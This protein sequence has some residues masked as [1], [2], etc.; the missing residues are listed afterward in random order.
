MPPYPR[1]YDT[2]A[3]CDYHYGAKGHS[4]ENC[5]ALMCKVQDLMKAGYVS[6]NYNASGVS[7]ITNNPL[8]NHP[9]PKINALTEDSTG[10]LKIRVSDVK[11]PMENVYKALVLAK[12]L[13]PRKI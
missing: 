9:G 13:H 7:N 6:F 2:N 1:S 12:I 4:T 8:P 5:V 10:S 11:K 3:S